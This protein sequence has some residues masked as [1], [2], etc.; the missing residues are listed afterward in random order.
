L[1]L[2][3]LLNRFTILF[4]F[5]FLDK[6]HIVPRRERLVLS[7]ERIWSILDK[8]SSLDQVD[9]LEIV[10]TQNRVFSQQPR[11]LSQKLFDLVELKTCINQELLF[12]VFVRIVVLEK[13]LDVSSCK[14][15]ICAPSN[16]ANQISD[17][18]V[19][20]KLI[21]WGHTVYTSKSVPATKFNPNFL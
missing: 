15:L 1:V 19:Y 13:R 21:L 16:L 7:A 6:A 18:L 12:R 9:N 10:Q 5:V 4:E 17:L 8:V 2:H 20:L 14:L 11:I 3:E